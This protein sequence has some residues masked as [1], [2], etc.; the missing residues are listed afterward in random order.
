MRLN[1]SAV[2]VPV[3]ILALTA[4]ASGSVHGAEITPG[5]VLVSHGARLAEYTLSGDLVQTINVAPPPSGFNSF[6][7]VVVSPSDAIH[8]V[9]DAAPMMLST[10]S[11]GTTT[12]RHDQPQ[13]GMNLA[14]VTYYGG[15]SADADY[16]YVPDRSNTAG[17]VSGIVRFPLNDLDSPDRFAIGYNFHAV[18]VGLNGLI[19]GLSRSGDLHGF[20]PTTLD[21]VH[22]FGVHAGSSVASV[23]VDADGTIYTLDIGGELHEFTSD[24]TFVRTV[25]PDVAAAVGVDMQ[26]APDGTMV[27]GSF[28]DG[29]V[30]TDTSLS[31]FSEFAIPLQSGAFN[32]AFVSFTTPVPEPGTLL[33]ALPLGF[34]LVARRRPV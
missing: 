10:N 16:V 24:G 34:A 13:D 4:T 19:Y 18:K 8:V 17:D 3:I 28:G 33:I 26:L 1:F 7:G 14:G 27:L 23:A 6:R 30:I 32:D 20:N 2:S 22:S 29:V 25:D 21:L 11:L 12:W 9:N 15:I 5:N 31:S